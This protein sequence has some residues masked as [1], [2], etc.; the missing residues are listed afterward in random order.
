M[1]EKEPK[2]TSIQIQAD[3]QVQ[4][5]SVS[6]HS[7]RHCLNE[8]GLHDR[9]P[10]KTPLLRGKHKK[11][12]LDFSENAHS[13]SE[14]MCFGQMKQNWS[15]LVNPINPVY[16]RK[17]ETFK[18]KNTMPTLKHG[19]VMFCCCFVASGTGGL[20]SEDYQGILELN[21]QPSVRKLPAV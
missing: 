1:V 9:R 5:T 12:S 7:I 3:R 14:R 18:E 16:R 6:S 21:I 2:K 8:N 15:F 17:N 11:A 19:G 4:G 20:K 10:R 13:P